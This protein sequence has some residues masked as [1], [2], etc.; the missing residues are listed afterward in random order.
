MLALA[1]AAPGA[2]AGLYALGTCPNPNGFGFGSTG[3]KSNAGAFSPYGTE[4]GQGDVIG[5]KLDLTSRS[6]SFSIS[7]TVAGGDLRGMGGCDSAAA[8]RRRRS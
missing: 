5:C 3:K 7:G 4:Y 6:L 2:A 8:V 1:P